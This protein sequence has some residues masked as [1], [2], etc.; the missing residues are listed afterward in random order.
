MVNLDELMRLHDAA[1]PGPWTVVFYTRVCS[2][3]KRKE[4][5]SCEEDDVPLK[6]R[7]KNPPT[8]ALPATLC[9]SLWSG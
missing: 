5:A 6:Q 7:E 4:V 9:L 3:T 8:S 2:E 1:T